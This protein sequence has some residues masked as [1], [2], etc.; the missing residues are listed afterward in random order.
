[1][2]WKRNSPGGSSG[3]SSSSQIYPPTLAPEDVERP[4]LQSSYFQFVD[5]KSK[6]RPS[7]FLRSTQLTVAVCLFIAL[8]V[9]FRIGVRMPLLI[10]TEQLFFESGEESAT[11]SNNNDNA[12]PSNESP[13]IS[14]SKSN[15]NKNIN[16]LN[17]C[18]SENRIKK[19][20]VI[21]GSG[22]AGLTAAKRLQN[23]AAS[24]PSS[25]CWSIE[26]TILEASN[27]FG[28][29]VGKDDDFT[30]YP[31]DLGASWVYDDKRL[32]IIAQEP[33]ME[34][35]LED[36]L[37]APF[38][39]DDYGT[40]KIKKSGE[41]KE[42][43]LLSEKDKIW[44]NYTWYDFFEQHVVSALQ[45]EQIIYDCSVDKIVQRRQSGEVS[46]FCGDRL[47]VAD[48]VIA[49][50]SLAVLQDDVIDFSPPLPPPLVKERDPMW[51]GLKFFLEFS[52]KFYD[53]YFVHSPS[54]G[55]LDWWDYSLIHL[56]PGGPNILSGY[57]MGDVN[58]KLEGKTEQEVV[59]ILLEDLD[60]IY[61][62]KIATKSYIR[63]KLVDWK[64]DPYVRGTYSS[65]LA[66]V[67]RAGP[68]VLW[69]GKLFIAGEA[70]PVP[71]K[72]NGWVDGA[73]MS[74]LHAAEIIL[75]QLDSTVNWFSI[76]R[77]IWK[78]T[79]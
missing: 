28:G 13:F 42:R 44:V 20:V 17:G 16:S 79:S 39:L 75:H 14:P 46:I 48:F 56:G 43:T 72:H 26:I 36:H 45:P 55:E 35:K 58:D 11:S 30:V 19:R 3:S 32:S 1:M 9:V 29:R 4:S 49:T 21:V 7:A 22:A 73:A 54:D 33:K 18:K 69:K 76:P 71:P 60:K 52:E 24:R 59:E 23:A 38:L 47:F 5:E 70:F 61:G 15:N 64:S 34:K 77:S 57:Y 53:D 8:T 51:R 31:I 68:Q 6:Q 63:H 12:Y 50:A 40:F 65:D 41:R 62:G 66:R 2:V 37:V 74:G 25:S 67:E 10:R 27:H 78:E